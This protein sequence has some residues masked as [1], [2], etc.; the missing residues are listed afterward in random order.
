MQVDGRNRSSKNSERFCE[1]AAER[2][3][4]D[5]KGYTRRAR[6]GKEKR[7]E[8]F[9]AL[10][11]SLSHSGMLSLSLSHSLAL[12]LSHTQKVTRVKDPLKIFVPIC[13]QI[14]VP[15]CAWPRSKA[16]F[17]PVL[18][19][20]DA[21]CSGPQERDLGTRSVPNKKV[22]RDKRGMGAIKEGWGLGVY[23]MARVR[24]E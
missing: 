10:S 22:V 15:I 5:V 2:G 6:P 17:G 11:S 19:V 1:T 7:R 21:L 20:S 18:F 14:F 9:S 3:G 13:A 4:R 8:G 24:S 23:A 12:P 16:K